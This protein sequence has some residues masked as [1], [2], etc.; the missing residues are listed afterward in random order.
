M[1]RRWRLPRLG[2]AALVALALHAVALFIFERAAR[3]IQLASAPT[4][5]GETFD[6]APIAEAE[7]RALGAAFGAWPGE[8][9]PAAIPAKGVP[10]VPHNPPPPPAPQ[11]ADVTAASA[12]ARTAGSVKKRKPP[13]AT[14]AIDAPTQ[15]SPEP[16]RPIPPV[17]APSPEPAV[18]PTPAPAARAATPDAQAA[19]PAPVTAQTSA[20]SDAAP[21]PATTDEIHTVGIRNG[22]ETDENKG[23]RAGAETMGRAPP[24]A[25]TAYFGRM[26]DKVRTHWH[27]SEVFRQTN[28]N[29]QMLG[30]IGAGRTTTLLV[31]LFPNGRIERIEVDT[32]SGSAPLDQEAVAAFER[33]QPLDQPPPESLDSTDRLRFRF[34]FHL[35][36]TVASFLAKLSHTVGQQW[37]PARALRA[38][39]GFDRTATLRVLLNGEGTIIYAA[40]LTSS[41]LDLLDTSML[42]AVKVGSVLPAPPPGMRRAGRLTPVRVIFHYSVRGRDHVR[43]QRES[44]SLTAAN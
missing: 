27:P 26:Q 44:R 28:P 9:G 25:L 23:E 20:P 43:S 35:D 12:A 8:P 15:V 10:A 36:L 18:R 37:K 16:V 42:A 11:P 29:S 30:D 6:V 4:E 17:A 24:S 39:A 14:V 2:G 31:T 33:A 13:I 7:A 32:P 38:F 21:V 41:G 34:N 3:R 5:P 40:V 22:E 1:A 19:P